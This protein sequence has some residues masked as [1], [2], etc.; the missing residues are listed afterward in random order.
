MKTSKFS[1]SLAVLAGFLVGCAAVWLVWPR[2]TTP[3]K[4]SEPDSFVV[5]AVKQ[6]Q[7]PAAQAQT[8]PAEKSS[9]P[10]APVPAAA[11]PRGAE[12]RKY[13]NEIKRD[14]S[15]PAS[16]NVHFFDYA[17]GGRKLSQQ[18]IDFFE[19]T[20]A[21]ASE[22]SDLIQASRT[23]VWKARNAQAQVTQ[24]PTGGV[25]VK[26]PPATVEPD[27]Y[28]KMMNGFQSVLG[29]DRFNDMMLYDDRQFDSMLNP[30]GDGDVQR[31][32]TIEPGNNGRYNIGVID[33]KGGFGV[34]GVQRI[35]PTLD[36]IKEYHPEWVE[37]VPVK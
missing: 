8:E 30:I 32:L 13:L 21:E 5:A 19:L 33:T 7:P 16:V 35:S 29:D 23:E 18:F 3:A 17:S 31:V 4:T 9:A 15:A 28:D 14:K 27:I 22:L 10:D 25:V 26:L 36:G 24:T 20:P 2:E 37:F 6:A 1:L 12:A 34:V 11:V